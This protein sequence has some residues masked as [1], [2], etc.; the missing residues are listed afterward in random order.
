MDRRALALP[1]APVAAMNLKLLDPREVRRR[2]GAR[3]GASG[4]VPL[5][6]AEGFIRQVLGWREYVRGDLLAL[7]ARV[8]RPQRARRRP[9]AAGALLD[10]RHRDGLPARRRRPDAATGY[11]HHI[12]RL[13]V[14][15]LFALLLGVDPRAVHEWYLAVYVDAVEWV[16]LPNTL[17]MCAVRRRRRDGVQALLRDGQVHRPDEQRLQGLPLRPEEAHRAPT[18][19]RSRRSTGTSL[20]GTRSCSPAIRGWRCSSGICRASRPP[21]C[22]GI[23]RQADDL[24]GQMS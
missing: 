22:G 9:A 17:G 18:P 15:G 13:M 5:A 12:Q 8:R 19:A 20:R 16:E 7:H 4:A 10:R 23:R 1:R 24:R 6:A 2:R 14:T 3:P 21:T 11:A